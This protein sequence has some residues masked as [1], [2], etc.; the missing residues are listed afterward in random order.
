MPPLLV[1]LCAAAASSVP[2]HA[3]PVTS[4]AAATAAICGPHTFKVNLS[5]VQLMC[6]AST[7]Q[8]LGANFTAA[9]CLAACCSRSNCTAWNYHVSSTN[10]SHHPTDCWLSV[11]DHPTAQKGTSDDVWAGGAKQATTPYHSGGTGGGAS[12][13]PLSKWFYYGAAGNLGDTLNRELTDQSITRLRARAD[14][15]RALGA[16]KEK[17]LVCPSSGRKNVPRRHN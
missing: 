10:P 13:Q 2:V 3:A 9:S 12:I 6:S 15:V 7:C 17:W 1:L 11:A 8:F 5:N 16:D 4:P 14:T